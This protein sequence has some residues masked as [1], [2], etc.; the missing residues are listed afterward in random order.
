MNSKK[1]RFGQIAAIAFTALVYAFLY[2]PIVVVVVFLFNASR[3]N[4]EFTGFTLA[5]YGI[6][7]QNA[8]LMSAFQNTLIV[9]AASTVFPR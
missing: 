9:A 1:H 8:S 6:M 5:W 7:L 3:M 2:L 4:I